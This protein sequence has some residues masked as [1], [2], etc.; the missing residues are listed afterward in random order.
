[1]TKA[2]VKR[3]GELAVSDQDEMIILFGESATPELEK[4]SVIQAVDGT[5][6]IS[7]EVGGQISFDDQ[8]YTVKHAGD[9]AATN[10]ATLAHVVI[11]FSGVPDE[12]S[13]SNALYVEPYTLPKINEGTVI[14]YH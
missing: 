10:L 9:L 7:V 1:M 2:I 8:I 6:K 5:G 14:T 12:D 4:V 13:L 11:V 3:I